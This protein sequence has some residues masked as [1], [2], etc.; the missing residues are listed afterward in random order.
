MDAHCKL[1][2]IKCPF[3]GIMGYASVK[4]MY[5]IYDLHFMQKKFLSVFVVL[6]AQTV[7]IRTSSNNV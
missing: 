1:R 2:A 3:G 5:Q 6:C 7:V 4:V